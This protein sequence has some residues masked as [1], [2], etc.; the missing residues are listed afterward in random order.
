LVRAA[1]HNRADNSL[2]FI[3]YFSLILGATRN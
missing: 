1:S 2:R 3:V